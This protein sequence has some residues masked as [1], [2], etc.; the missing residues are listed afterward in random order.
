VAPAIDPAW[1]VDRLD[2]GCRPQA[3]SSNS[4]SNLRL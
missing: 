4:P 2:P 3:G 1:P